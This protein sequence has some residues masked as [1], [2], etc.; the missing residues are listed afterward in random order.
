MRCSWEF[1]GSP[2]SQVKNTPRPTSTVNHASGLHRVICLK[3]RRAGPLPGI[4]QHVICNRKSAALDVGNGT[5]ND[6]AVTSACLD[7]VA[8]EACL[9][10]ELF[11]FTI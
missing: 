9:E 6:I 7:S 10:T 11:L 5:S 1:S 4:G 8:S 3:G 2:Q